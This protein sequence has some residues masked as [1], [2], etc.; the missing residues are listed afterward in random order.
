MDKKT[1]YQ[2]LRGQIERGE[3]SLQQG[4]R[5]IGY[6]PATG[7]D[8]S[9]E[10]R[11]LMIGDKLIVTRIT[12]G[13]PTSKY[14]QRPRLRFNLGYW[15]GAVLTAKGLDDELEDVAQAVRGRDP[16][17]DAGLAY[18]RDVIRGQG[19]DGQSSL[20]AWT[21]F[22]AELTEPNLIFQIEANPCSE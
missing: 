17:Y 9:C 4:Y 3:I 16:F 8:T 5:V 2:D 6:D 1:M 11:G 21:E 15:D 19:P 22:L 10:V 14:L 7:P 18:G 13:I 12:H 20:R